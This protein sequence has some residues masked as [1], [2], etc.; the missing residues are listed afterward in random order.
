MM[1]KRSCSTLFPG[2]PFIIMFRP[3]WLTIGHAFRVQKQFTLEPIQ[4]G[5]LEL[6]DPDGNVYVLQAHEEQFPLESLSQ[7]DEQLKKL[8]KG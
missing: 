6:V 4:L 1:N 3:G 7:L 8:P 5:L 2:L